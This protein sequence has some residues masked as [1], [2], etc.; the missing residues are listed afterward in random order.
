MRGRSTD[1]HTPIGDGVKQT[2]SVGKIKSQRAIG[3]H[4][5]KEKRKG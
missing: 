1:K 4:R 2:E 3:R 5:E